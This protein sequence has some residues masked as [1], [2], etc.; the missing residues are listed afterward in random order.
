MCGLLYSRKMRG[1]HTARRTSHGRCAACFKVFYDVG[2]TLRAGDVIAS[3]KSA[4]QLRIQGG[5]AD[6]YHRIR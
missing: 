4:V 2:H 6:I 5:T 3:L 1:T